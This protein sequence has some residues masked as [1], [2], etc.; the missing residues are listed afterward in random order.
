MQLKHCIK[1]ILLGQ[2]KRFQLFTEAEMHMP[3]TKFHM[4]GLDLNPQKSC[5]CMTS[6][7]MTSRIITGKPTRSGTH[8]ILANAYAAFNA[9]NEHTTSGYLWPPSLV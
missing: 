8:E 7:K 9:K 1:A 4:K 5:T 6:S 3:N 2:L